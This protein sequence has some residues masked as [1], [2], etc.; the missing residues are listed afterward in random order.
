MDPLAGHCW[1]PLVSNDHS[2]FR[3]ASQRTDHEFVRPQGVSWCSVGIGV[4]LFL[5]RPIPLV[6]PLSWKRQASQ[7]SRV[8]LQAHAIGK[9]GKLNQGGWVP[10][11]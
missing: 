4:V 11:K 9:L 1:L 10:W 5:G 3:H 6:Q 8:T 2:S 7:W